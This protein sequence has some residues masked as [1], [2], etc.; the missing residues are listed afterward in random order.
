M[1]LKRT[2]R[3]F[4]QIFLPEGMQELYV[5]DNEYF[6]G[7]SLIPVQKSK[8]QKLSLEKCQRVHLELLAKLVEQSQTLKILSIIDCKKYSSLFQTS[9]AH[10]IFAG[11]FFTPF[12]PR[13]ILLRKF[14][15]FKRLDR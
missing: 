2:T 1:Y 15:S 6:L 4:E 12:K 14:R 3:Q 13:R 5:S 8:I 9:R 11:D 10:R 7:K